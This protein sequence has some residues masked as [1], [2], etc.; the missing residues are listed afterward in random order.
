MRAVLVDKCPKCGN[1]YYPGIRDPWASG[2]CCPDCA[3]PEKIY[4]CQCGKKL[5]RRHHRNNYII[6]ICPDCQKKKR[7][8]RQKRYKA[9]LKLKNVLK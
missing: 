4:Y 9:L 2:L 1:E 6:P 8:E 3:F 7:R 5:V